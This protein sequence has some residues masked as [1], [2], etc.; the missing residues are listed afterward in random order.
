[1]DELL[2][3]GVFTFARKQLSTF[4]RKVFTFA[5][6]ATALFCRPWETDF[7]FYPMA[8]DDDDFNPPRMPSP[9]AS[10]GESGGWGGIRTLVDG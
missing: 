9:P 2:P 3:C 8:L 4:A 7:Q 1:M 5:R 10:A 6:N